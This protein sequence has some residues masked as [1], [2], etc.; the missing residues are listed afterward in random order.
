MRGRKEWEVR[1]SRGAHLLADMRPTVLLSK[2]RSCRKLRHPLHTVDLVILSLPILYYLAFIA[3][4]V[5]RTSFY[6]LKM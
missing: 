6:R 2:R 1:E 3:V 5:D 4:I